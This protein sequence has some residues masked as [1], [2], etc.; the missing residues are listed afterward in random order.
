MDIQTIK[1]WFLTGKK[2]TQQQFHAVF[3]SFRHK[4]DQIPMADVYGLNDALGTKQPAGNY[5][6][7]H[8]PIKTINNRTIT[9][10]GNIDLQNN[11]PVVSL[12][13]DDAQVTIQPNMLFV[14]QDL[15]LPELTITR[16]QAQPGIVNEYMLRITFNAQNTSP[17]IIFDGFQLHWV[18]DAPVFVAGK[19]YEISIVDNFALCVEF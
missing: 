13:N 9:G 16:G 7:E 10:T 6:T 15:Q 4:D 2:P 3:D 18:G 14:F 1:N 19:T 5:L 12:G 17:T 11:I 8:Q